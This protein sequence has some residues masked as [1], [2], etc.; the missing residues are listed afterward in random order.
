MPIFYLLNG[1]RTAIYIILL[2]YLGIRLGASGLIKMP[3]PLRHIR[4]IYIHI[5]NVGA[6]F[7]PFFILQLCI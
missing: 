1:A 2:Y 7:N 3:T 4:P 6:G 5:Y